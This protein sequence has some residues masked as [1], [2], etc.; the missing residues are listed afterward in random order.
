M[1]DMNKIEETKKL[2]KT[3]TL[4]ALKSNLIVKD[5]YENLIEIFLEV[6]MMLFWITP[7]KIDLIKTKDVVNSWDWDSNIYSEDAIKVYQGE[8]SYFIW[9]EDTNWYLDDYYH[10]TNHD[11]SIKLSE[12]KVLQIPANVF[13]IQKLITNGLW[14][15]DKNNIPKLSEIEPDDVEEVIS[16]DDQHVL[17][18][19]TVE[20]LEVVS[21]EEWV[22]I[23]Q[24]EKWFNE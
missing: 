6:N 20:N 19:T 18:G 8:D 5:L 21:R 16:W 7:F 3:S 14:K 9:K 1:I 23:M 11:I 24:R 17:I 15:F 4:K 13:E 22:K 10:C 12:F 2:I